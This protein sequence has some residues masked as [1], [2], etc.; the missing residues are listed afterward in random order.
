MN[1]AINYYSAAQ[2]HADAIR[3]ARRN[4][5]ADVPAR[6]RRAASVRS[7]WLL[8]AVARRAPLRPLL[9]ARL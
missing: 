1:S 2:M 3:E 9:L 8:A 4:P 5:Q 6:E 7:H